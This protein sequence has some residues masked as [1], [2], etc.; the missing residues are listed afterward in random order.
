[1]EALSLAL[2]AIGKGFADAAR[3][4]QVME[5]QQDMT[6]TA[7]DDTLPANEGK[8]RW[9]AVTGMAVNEAYVG[10]G[11]RMLYDSSRQ[12]EV[13]MHAWCLSAIDEENSYI[14]STIWNPIRKK[15]ETMRLHR[16]LFADEIEAY[17]L[18]HI[19]RKSKHDNRRAN[20]RS[21]DNG[22][23]RRNSDLKR[24]GVVPDDVKKVWIAQWS[25]K[26][27]KKCVKEFKWSNYGGEELAHAAAAAYR[28]EQAD[29]VVAEIT[30]LQAEAKAK[31]KELVIP[32]HVSK[33]QSTNTGFKGLHR[34][35]DRKS[36]RVFVE[37]IITIQKRRICTTFSP[38]QY[39]GDYNKALEAAKAWRDEQEAA[40]LTAPLRKAKRMRVGRY[41][42]RLKK[43]RRV[44]IEQSDE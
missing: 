19:D 14:Q 40:R 36:G 20:L 4:L 7:W 41:R 2:A 6:N 37:A 10:H 25:D 16:Y 17:E 24:D 8:N 35:Y 43:L 1:M 42:P 23:N 28:R 30:A 13:A 15:H 3:A 29:A 27:G 34:R 22:M 33:P 5:R 44:E 21:G 26:H 11:R 12:E 39:N 18:D 38:S 31:G 32:R 9:R